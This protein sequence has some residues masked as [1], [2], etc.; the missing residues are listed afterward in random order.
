MN[1]PKSTTLAPNR[2][3]M[4]LAFG[5]LGLVICI[6]FSI[7]G[8]IMANKDLAEMAA[9]RMDPSGEGLTGAGKILC[10]VAVAVQVIGMIFAILFFVGM[11]GVA[12]T[13]QN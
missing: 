7:I 12:A 2:G 13:A 5:I 9:G 8:W 11:V 3:G 4:I 10:M 1:E 6:I